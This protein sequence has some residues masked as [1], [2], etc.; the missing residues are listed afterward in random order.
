M[1]HVS[2]RIALLDVL[3][4][5]KSRRSLHAQSMWKTETKQFAET[6]RWYQ[7]MLKQN[8]LSTL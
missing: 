4:Y 6:E 5:G 8:K 3:T 2:Y 1:F 7:C